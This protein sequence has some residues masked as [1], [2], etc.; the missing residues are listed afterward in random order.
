MGFT[1]K[2]LILGFLLGVLSLNTSAQ[3]CSNERLTLT[4]DQIKKLENAWGGAFSAHQEKLEEAFAKFKPSDYRAYAKYKVSDWL[5]KLNRNRSKM[6]CGWKTFGRPFDSDFQ[7]IKSIV[8]AMTELNTVSIKMQSYLKSSN[9]SDL[10]FIESK[11][12][13]LSALSNPYK[14]FH[15]KPNK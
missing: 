7:T 1:S 2:S 4:A 3:E 6:D 8:I 5:P 9:I 12:T 13:E 11:L 15:P 14:E 10:K